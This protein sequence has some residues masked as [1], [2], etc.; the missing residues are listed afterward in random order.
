MSDVICQIVSGELPAAVVVRDDQMVVFLD[1][2]PVFKGHVLIAPVRH[3]DTMLDLPSELMVPLLGTAQRVA[4]AVGRA[5]GAEGT[6]M[7]I[8]NV[9]SQSVPHLHLHVVPRTKGD[10]LRG[11]FWPRTS[12]APGEIEAYATLIKD[13]LG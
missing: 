7:A 4:E 11:F 1:H 10:K 2:R 13:A 9:V 8:N 5:L 6:F 12:Y 3:V